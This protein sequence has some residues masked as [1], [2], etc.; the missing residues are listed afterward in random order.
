MELNLDISFNNFSGP[1]PR[2]LGSWANIERM[3][4]S[5]NN[6]TGEL[7]ETFAML[8]KIEDFRV[9]DSHFSGR[10]TDLSGPESPIPSL[11]KMKNMKTLRVNGSMVHNFCLYQKSSVNSKLWMLR[12]CNLTGQLPPYLGQMTKLKTLDLSFNQLTGE[13]PS[14]FASLAKA[15]Y[16]YAI[17]MTNLILNWKLADWTF[18]CLAERQLTCLRAR[19]K[20]IV[21]LYYSLH[22]NCGGNQFTVPGKNGTQYDDDIFSAGPSFYES[23]TNWALSSTGYFTDDDRTTDAFIWTNETRLSMANPQLYMNARLSPISLTYFGFCLGNG[24]YTV[25]LYFAEIM[26]RKGKTY[27]SVGRRI[28][29]IYIQVTIASTSMYTHQ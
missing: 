24:S 21:H 11:D 19:Q 23:K 4:L 9:S 14:S 13:I 18:T 8:T 2:E 10:I 6:F 27:R 17:G 20:A 28:F 12:N 15:D 29:D 22:I 3:L 25:S 26:F 7:P 1:L 16:M 5:S